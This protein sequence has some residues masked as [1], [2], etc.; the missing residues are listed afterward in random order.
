MN[1]IIIAIFYKIKHIFI[2]RRSQSHLIL[3][4]YKKVNIHFPFQG[5][6]RNYYYYDYLNYYSNYQMA[7]RVWFLTLNNKFHNFNIIFTFQLS[8]TKFIFL[9]FIINIFFLIQTFFVS[10]LFYSSFELLYLISFIVIY[11]FNNDNFYSLWWFY[12]C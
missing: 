4:Q 7:F 11:F 10:S 6:L 8:I 2:N 9:V 5:H 3:N 1:I 12:Y